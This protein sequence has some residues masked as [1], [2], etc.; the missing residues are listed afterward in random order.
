M[1][2][3]V[4]EAQGTSAGWW[5]VQKG[6]TGVCVLEVS[7]LLRSLIPAQRWPEAQVNVLQCAT[8]CQCFLLANRRL[9]PV[10]GSSGGVAHH[11][12]IFSSLYWKKVKRCYLG[13]SLLLLTRVSL[14]C[15]ILSG[16][17]HSGPLASPPLSRTV[18]VTRLELAGDISLDN[19]C[20]LL[21]AWYFSSTNFWDLEVHWRL[22][23]KQE[24][25]V[26]HGK[27]SDRDANQRNSAG[28]ILSSVARQTWHVL[29]GQV[30]VNQYFRIHISSCFLSL[31]LLCYLSDSCSIDRTKRR[32]VFDSCRMILNFSGV[33]AQVSRFLERREKRKQDGREE[34]KPDFQGR[35]THLLICRILNKDVRP[36]RA[37]RILRGE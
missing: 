37:Y 9:D 36:Q 33:S 31:Q 12:L 8:K 23:G 10:R 5:G 28:E 29:A 30:A 34:E 20:S 22:T 1:E 32:Q 14:Q 26:A 35:D 16:P 17:L 4:E 6:H 2:C 19:T 3:R 27:G 11:G 21:T 24:R 13:P 18:P 15:W 25:R 7:F